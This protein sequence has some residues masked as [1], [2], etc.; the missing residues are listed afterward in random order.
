[1]FHLLLPQET[2][3]HRQEEDL[4]L[5]LLRQETYRHLQVEESRHHLE[6]VMSRLL[7]EEDLP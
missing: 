6:E 2:Y 4:H 1:M 5:L 3:H 7:P